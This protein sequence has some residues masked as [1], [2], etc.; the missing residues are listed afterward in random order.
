MTGMY[1]GAFFSLLVIM[2]AAT[3]LFIYTWLQSHG[4]NHSGHG[5]LDLAA[6][7]EGED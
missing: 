7:D 2:L 3:V 4:I 1:F 6:G 5:H